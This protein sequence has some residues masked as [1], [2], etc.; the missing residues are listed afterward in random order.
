MPVTAEKTLS[1]RINETGGTT[2]KAKQDKF[3]IS[4]ERTAFV[5]A[6]GALGVTKQW[7]DQRTLNNTTENLDLAGV[8]TNAFGLVVT[9]TKVRIW[10][11]KNTS[12]TSNIVVGAHATAPW[13]GFL[14]AE[15]TITLRPGAELLLTDPTVTAGAVVAGT[16]DMLKVTSNAVD[17]AYDIALGGE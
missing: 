9:F 2:K 14:N 6:S 7:N 15:G 13:V 11:I 12:P 5:A 1:L 4:A 17:G 3:E 16:G 10:Y 8:L